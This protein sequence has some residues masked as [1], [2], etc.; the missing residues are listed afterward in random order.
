MITR[1][2]KLAGDREM[3]KAEF[4]WRPLTVS[5]SA[6]RCLGPPP[7]ARFRIWPRY[8]GGILSE[9]EWDMDPIVLQ[10]TV[11]DAIF[12]TRAQ[13]P[14]VGDFFKLIQGPI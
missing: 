11:E 12:I 4:T 1:L 8:R 13:W 7:D 10:S 9:T 14:L 3:G 6:P 5:S 2:H